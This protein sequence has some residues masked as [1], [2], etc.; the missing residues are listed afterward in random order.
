V[1]TGHIMITNDQAL[2]LHMCLLYL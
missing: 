1:Q 2:W